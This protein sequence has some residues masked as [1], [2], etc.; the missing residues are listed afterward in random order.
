MPHA[1]KARQVPLIR[2]GLALT[3]QAEEP[4]PADGQFRGGTNAVGYVSD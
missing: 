3:G 4:I 1:P 2:E